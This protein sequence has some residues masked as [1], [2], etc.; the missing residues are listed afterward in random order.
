MIYIIHKMLILLEHHVNYFKDS[1]FECFFKQLAFILL[2][3]NYFFSRH[4]MMESLS[5]DKGNINK[6]IRVLC[7]LKELNYTAINDITNLFRLEK[8][9]CFEIFR[10]FLSM[11]QKTIII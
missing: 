4:I 3:K 8:E 5:L 10:I 1:I 9:E 2:E 7:R 6:Y 11:K